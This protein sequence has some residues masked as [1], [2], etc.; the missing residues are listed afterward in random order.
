MA[1]PALTHIQF[2]AKLAIEGC[3]PMVEGKQPAKMPI[4]AMPIEPEMRAKAGADP[5]ALAVIYPVGDSG[6]FFQMH[7]AT[8]RVWFNNVN[9][10]GALETFERALLTGYPKAT[11][12]EQ[13]D[14]PMPGMRVRLYNVPVDAKH[15]ASVEVTYPTTPEARKQFIIRVHA[16]Q[17]V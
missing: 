10:D 4:E 7:N 14:H 6:V 9:M 16:Q 2:A 15:F 1:A 11:F 12:V 13:L 5:D 17:V 8:A 3:L